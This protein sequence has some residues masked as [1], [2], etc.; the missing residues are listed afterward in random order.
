MLQTIG[1]GWAPWSTRAEA[2]NHRNPCAPKR[3]NPCNPCSAKRAN[4][5]NPRTAKAANPCNPCSAKRA[6]PRKARG[7]RKQ[8]KLIGWGKNYV[9]Y[10]RT[11]G[12]VSSA[13]HGGRLV[14]SYVA[15]KKAAQIYRRN[16]N[17]VR[18]KRKSGYQAFPVGTIIAKESFVKDKKGEPGK[19][20]PVFF[21]RKEAKGY[22]PG[23]GD[24]SYAFTRP[25]FTLIGEGKTGNV[26]FC[27]ACH[28]IVKNRD[29]V[30]A[31]D[32]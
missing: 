17:L 15:P 29:M 28:V 30:Y 9:I 20:G 5:C 26:A 11:T 1:W 10:E 6:N 13:S 12:F 16:A 19:R 31:V 25:D 27:R 24:W 4:P 32:R 8:A 2:A 21:M 22:D 14:V 3:S 7:K 18:K 23:G